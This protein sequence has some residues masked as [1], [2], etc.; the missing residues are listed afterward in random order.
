MTAES[1][2]LELVSKNLKYDLDA[3]QLVSDTK[4]IVQDFNSR[5]QINSIYT[6]KISGQHCLASSLKSLT[7]CKSFKS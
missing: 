1:E 7:L 3:N 5:L 4:T 2:I 6:R